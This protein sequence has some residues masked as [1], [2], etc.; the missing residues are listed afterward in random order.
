MDAKTKRHLIE[1]GAVTAACVI[2]YLLLRGG[3][4][5]GGQ[6][7]DSAPPFALPGDGISSSTPNGVTLPASTLG[8]PGPITIGGNYNPFAAGNSSNTGPV[9]QTFNTP[10]MPVVS[11]DSNGDC[12]CDG[13]DTQSGAMNVFS[14]PANLQSYLSNVLGS[15]NYAGTFMPAVS[16][17][18]AGGA[19]NSAGLTSAT[20]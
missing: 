20:L 16:G 11:G 9:I 10:Q 17:Y 18:L 12:C 14:S 19:Y 5:S 2:A 6:T 3:P 4:A 13:C 1:G 15:S 8:T 7:V